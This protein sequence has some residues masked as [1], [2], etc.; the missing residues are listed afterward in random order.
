MIISDI[1]RHTPTGKV[2]SVVQLSATRAYVNFRNASH[3]FTWVELGELELANGPPPIPRSLWVVVSLRAGTT[4]II[5]D[6]EGIVLHA[7]EADA[8]AV[9]YRMMSDGNVYDVERL[10]K[11]LA[12]PVHRA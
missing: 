12:H 7:T 3:P 8:A 9:A 4:V 2:G 1:V 5:G 11:V 6:A 10:A